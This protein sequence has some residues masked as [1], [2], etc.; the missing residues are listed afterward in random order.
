MNLLEE[1]FSG[2]T[3]IFPGNFCSYYTRENISTLINLQINILFLTIFQ[4][5]SSVQIEKSEE[6]SCSITAYL[7]N[8]LYTYEAID[9]AAVSPGDSIPIRWIA[10]LGCSSKTKS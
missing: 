2:W 9:R 5:T 6:M 4:A 10:P 3:N 7:M 8:F 1:S